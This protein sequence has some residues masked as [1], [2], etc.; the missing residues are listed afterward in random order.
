MEVYEWIGDAVIGELVTRC[1]LAQFHVAPLSARVFRNLRL[2]VVTNEN[3]AMVFDHMGYQ[4]RGVESRLRRLKEKADVV[5]AIAG[6]LVVRLELQRRDER[7]TLALDA[8]RTIALHLQGPLTASF[9]AFDCLPTE[10]LDDDTGEL[11]IHDG[12]TDA[13]DEKIALDSGRRMVADKSF[14]DLIEECEFDDKPR[15]DHATSAATAPFHAF[16]VR[17]DNTMS[18]APHWMGDT[19]MVAV[20]RRVLARLCSIRPDHVL[21]SSAEMFNVFKVYGMTVL[22]ERVSLRLAFPRVASRL[23]TSNRLTLTVNPSQLTTERQSILCVNNLAFCARV[24][25]VAGDI[26]TQGSNCDVNLARLQANTLRAVVGF[27]SAIASENGPSMADDV[28]SV[29]YRLAVA[30]AATC[31]VAPSIPRREPLSVLPFATNVAREFMTSPACEDM[32]RPGERPAD[33]PAPALRLR[34]C[35][36]ELTENLFETLDAQRRQAQGPKEEM[37]VF[38]KRRRKRSEHVHDD[39]DQRSPTGSLAR[40]T[41]RR[42]LFC[43]EELVVLFAQRRPKSVE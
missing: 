24:L 3:L 39:N 13:L 30:D 22:A 27:F 23:G 14:V 20:Q 41:H 29:L 28:A 21:L 37:P 33:A 36:S 32:H 6:E 11:I 9:N 42:F 40:F 35:D 16:V 10:H 34:K 25:G 31:Q 7:T 4:R 12:S 19:D 43:L 15:G 2:G 18:C 38:E 5:E 17:V 26:Q 8:A 1:L